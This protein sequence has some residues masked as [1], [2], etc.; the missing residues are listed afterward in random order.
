RIAGDGPARN[1]LLQALQPW[2]ESGRVEYLGALAADQIGPQVFAN[3]DVFLLTS[4]WET[5]PIVI[6]EAMAAG[7][8][9]VSSRYIGSGLEGALQHEGNCLM[10]PVGDSEA[11]A[12]QLARTRDVDLRGALT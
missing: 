8:A 9:V 12:T 1:S 3:A 6:W 2:I 5:G 10:F 7:V 4:S 11:A